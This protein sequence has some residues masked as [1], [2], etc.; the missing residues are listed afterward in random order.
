[1]ITILFL[2]EN[3]SI[4]LSNHIFLNVIQKSTTSKNKKDKLNFIH[5]KNL[6]HQNLYHQREREKAS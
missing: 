4:N 1:M 2:G 3:T 5:I 6:Y